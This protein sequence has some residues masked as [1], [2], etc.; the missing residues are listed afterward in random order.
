MRKE[1]IKR[2]PG[3]YWQIGMLESWFSDMAK[4]GLILRTFWGNSARFIKGEPLQ[5]RYRIDICQNREKSHEQAELYAES[6]WYFVTNYAEFFIYASL[7]ENN[8]PE[9][10]SDPA[11]QAFTL[12]RLLRKFALTAILFSFLIL[13]SCIHLFSKLSLAIELVEGDYTTVVMFS[14][15]FFFVYED[16]K[17]LISILRLKTTLSE[18]QP[19]NHSAPWKKNRIISVILYSIFFTV[20]LS[21]SIISFISADSIR[22]E[23]LPAASNT[24][25]IVRLVDIE[26]N[27]DLM[28]GLTDIQ[29]NVDLNNSY[30]YDSSFFAP[31]QYNTS[32]NGIIKNEKWKTDGITGSKEYSPDIETKLYKLRYTS[33][34]E[35]VLSGF[36]KRYATTTVGKNFTEIRNQNFDKLMVYQEKN[37]IELFAAK[38]KFVVWVLYNGNANRDTVIEAVADKID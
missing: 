35:W 36:I 19:I 6:G 18:G 30:S 3:E 5:M 33:M 10:H 28:R 25:P 16:F 26:K 31:S 29:K 15:L 24:L 4:E 12:R 34:N 27:P 8:A 9:L 7:T 2:T 32:E 20:F 37:T 23:T 11:E 1:I 17:A 38:G 14:F 21:L 22:T 13:V